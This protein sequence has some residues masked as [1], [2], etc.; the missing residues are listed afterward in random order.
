MQPGISQKNLV[1]ASVA[2]EILVQVAYAIGI[3]KPVGLYVNTFGTAKVKNEKGKILTD[4]EISNRI[5]SIFD[6]RPGAI[7]KRFGLK[8]PIFLETATYGH[9]GRD[10]FK[11]QVKIGVNGKQELKE[12][13]F[14]SWEKLDYVD[15]IKKEF[16]I[17]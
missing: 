12:I 16:G 9:F 15:K 6:M 5:E 2:D 1:A 3:A 4:G 17:K 10:P 14:F 7:V 13:E 11:R 8:N